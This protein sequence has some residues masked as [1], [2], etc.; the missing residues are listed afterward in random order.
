MTKKGYILAKAPVHF[1]LTLS[2]HARNLHY[3]T[4][5]K[6]TSLS[7]GKRLQNGSEKEVHLTVMNVH[8]IH[9]KS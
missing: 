9:F 7:T 4:N 6:W 5:Y 1:S 2:L 3:E 8:F